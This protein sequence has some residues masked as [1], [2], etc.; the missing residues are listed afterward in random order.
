M[1]VRYVLRCLKG[2]DVAEQ[3]EKR[4]KNGVIEALSTNQR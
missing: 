3:E 1:G 4:Q 2:V